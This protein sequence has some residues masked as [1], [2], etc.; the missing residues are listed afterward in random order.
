MD[1]QRAG[2]AVRRARAQ[3]YHTLEAFSAA[4]GVSVSVLSDL[5]RGT[6]SN[7]TTETLARVEGALGWAPGAIAEVAGGKPVRRRDDEELSRLLEAWPHLMQQAR[8]ILADLAER[9][10]ELHF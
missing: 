10:A 3:R 9:A 1:W 8:L 2:I 7:F 6:R 4:I 5:E